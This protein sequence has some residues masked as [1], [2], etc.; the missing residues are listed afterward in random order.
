MDS[1]AYFCQ[2]LSRFSVRG[3]NARIYGR[4]KRQHFG[5]HHLHLEPG[6][7]L[8]IFSYF[9]IWNKYLF[10]SIFV[11]ILDITIS[12]SSLAGWLGNIICFKYFLIERF[13]PNIF[14]FKYLFKYFKVK[15]QMLMIYHV[16][17]QMTHIVNLMI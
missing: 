4:D 15:V 9:N 7:L 10:I 13:V 12:I 6:W 5:Y 17:T 16:Q 14:F 1:H 2:L 11:S 8:Q 3:R